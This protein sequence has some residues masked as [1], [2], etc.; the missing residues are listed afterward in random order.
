MAN[1]N[2]VATS[3]ITPQYHGQLLTLGLTEKNCKFLSMIGGLG[4]FASGGAKIA[5]AFKYPLNSNNAL[6]TPTQQDIPEDTASTAP[7]PRNYDRAQD[8][9]GYIQIF[10]KGVGST[11]AAESETAKLSGLALTGEVEDLNDPFVSNF[12]MT[13][14][15]LAMDVEWHML[16]GK[17]NESAA[18]NEASR[19]AGLFATQNKDAGA[20]HTINTNKVDCGGDALTV[21]DVDAM[22]LLLKE[23]SYAPMKNPVF[24]G[25]YSVLKKLADLYG[26]TVMAGPTNN[27]GTVSGQIDTIVTQAGKFPLVEVPQ[28]PAANIGLIDLA[29]VSPVFLPVPEKNGRPGG[30]LFYTPTAMTG[31]ADKGQI[32]GQIGM[33]YTAEEYHGKLYN[34]I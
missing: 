3:W 19:M 4:G 6:D 5:K 30:V 15:Q 16:N 12:N 22:L 24:I 34:F 10:H 23:T 13:M 32:Y 11:W 9:F 17:L 8:E 18:S 7:T 27:M 31:A 33:T 20:A 28:C 29:Y 21:A 1:T 2:A 14:K 26:V 25:R